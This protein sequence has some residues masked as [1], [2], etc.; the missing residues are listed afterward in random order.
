MCRMLSGA[1]HSVS[2]IFIVLEPQNV[3]WAETLFL[4]VSV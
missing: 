3:G 4:T 2:N 1:P